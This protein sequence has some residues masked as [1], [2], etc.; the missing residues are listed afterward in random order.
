MKQL[1]RLFVIYAEA[2]TEPG[3]VRWERIKYLGAVFSEFFP[4]I[5]NIGTETGK[6]LCNR[7]III[8]GYVKSDRFS[9]GFF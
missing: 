8:R 9:C 5:I 1:H 3:T 6:I 4:Q 7:E 2:A